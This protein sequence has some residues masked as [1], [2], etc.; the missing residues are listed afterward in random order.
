MRLNSKGKSLFI[1][2]SLF[3]ISIAVASIFMTQT[4]MDRLLRQD[5]RTDGMGWAQSVADQTHNLDA[6]LTGEPSFSLTERILGMNMRAPARA[7]PQ[8]QRQ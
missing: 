7:P 8:A 2:A 3:T 6:L 4:I 1:I 5:A